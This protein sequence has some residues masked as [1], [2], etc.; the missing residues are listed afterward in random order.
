MQ[1]GPLEKKK[2]MTTEIMK[3]KMREEEC[4]LIETK[5]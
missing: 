4:S 2:E 3:C 1:K 5:T